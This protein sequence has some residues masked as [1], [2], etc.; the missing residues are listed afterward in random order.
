MQWDL[1]S[2]E[3]ILKTVPFTVEKLALFDRAQQKPM[4]HPYYRLTCADWVNVLAITPDR[5]AVLIR[6]SRAGSLSDILEVPGGMVDSHEKDVTLAAM[7]ELEEETGYTSKTA[8]F[9]GK[10]NPNP[11]LFDNNVHMF[12]VLNAVPN[13]RRQHFPDASEL[14][15]TELVPISELDAMVRTG[16]INHAL[17]ALTIMMARKYLDNMH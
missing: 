1:L 16:Q 6:Q 15:A 2:K 17:A 13:E 4:S 9:L 14:I 7:R 12:L 11:A 5:K 3:S 10:I 8:L